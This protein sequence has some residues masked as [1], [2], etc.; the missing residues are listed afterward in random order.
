MRGRSGREWSAWKTAGW[1]PESVLTAAVSPD[2]GS[3]GTRIAF[4]ILLTDTVMDHR[5]HVIVDGNQLVNSGATD[6]TDVGATAGPVQC[7]WFGGIDA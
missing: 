7:G 5:A 1:A 3:L 2:A 4:E 6:E